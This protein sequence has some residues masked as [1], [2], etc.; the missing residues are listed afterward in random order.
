MKR[1]LVT[2]A[3]VA[4][5][6]ATTYAQGR[7]GFDNL[8]NLNAI[9]I[10]TDPLGAV[11]GQGAPGANVGAT[12]SIQLLWSVGTFTG[13]AEEFMAA[14]TGSS[15]PVAFFGTTGG[16]PTTDGAGLF[17]GGVVAM[18]GPGGAYT[19]LARAW[20]NGGTLA[21]YNAA[22]GAGANTGYSQLL[23]LNVTEPPTPAVFAAFPSFTVAGVIPEP[24]TFVLAGL[25]LASLLLFRR[26]K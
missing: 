1:T 10:T 12:Y 14:A 4:L 24:S 23:N 9:T 3:L 20:Y 6:A 22:L 2:L 18:G 5:S 17:D 7:V 21:T 13:T 11:G 19:F 26:R 16:S 15:T 25:G 8:G